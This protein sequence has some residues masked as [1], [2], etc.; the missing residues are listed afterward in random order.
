[1]R[2]VET[3]RLRVALSRASRAIH[4]AMES[5]QRQVADGTCCVPFHADYEDSGRLSLSQIMSSALETAGKFSIHM[6]IAD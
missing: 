1:M 6:K 4:V 2:G 3:S 5:P